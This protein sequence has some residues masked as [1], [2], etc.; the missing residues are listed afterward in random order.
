MAV[1]ATMRG[2]TRD[3]TVQQKSQ[4]LLSELELILRDVDNV[5]KRSAVVEKHFEKAKESLRLLEVSAEKVRRRGLTMRNI[6]SG[7]E[8]QEVLKEQEGQEVSEEVV[9]VGVAAQKRKTKNNR[10]SSV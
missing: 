7:M 6:E 4:Y 8:E 1:L 2:V 3:L 9:V 5:V 10:V